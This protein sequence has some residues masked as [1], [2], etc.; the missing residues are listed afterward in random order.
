MAQQCENAATLLVIPELGVTAFEWIKL[1]EL[2]FDVMV[3]RI[4]RN[5]PWFWNRRHQKRTMVADC[6]SKCLG[7]G[8][9]AHRTSRATCTSDNPTAESH[10]CANWKQTSAKQ[11]GFERVLVHKISENVVYLVK[12]HGRFGWNVRPF[13]R[14]DFDSKFT[15]ISIFSAT[16]NDL[17]KFQVAITSF[18]NYFRVYFRKWFFFYLFRRPKGSST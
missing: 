7:R 12:I 6:G 13:T 3:T 11:A 8:H 4:K 18:I 2:N 1:N 16:R 10:R 14:A 5:L 17:C 15:S 9:R